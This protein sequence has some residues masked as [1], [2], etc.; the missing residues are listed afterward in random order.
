ME[1]DEPKQQWNMMMKCKTTEHLAG[2]IHR[3]REMIRGDDANAVRCRKGFHG[4][5]SNQ[6][7]SKYGHYH[8][9][10]ADMRFDYT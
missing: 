9:M 1:S 2:K 5:F 6:H 10:R 4:S 7:Q 8:P 3:I